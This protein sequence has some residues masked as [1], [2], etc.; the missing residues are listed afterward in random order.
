MA[1]TPTVWQDRISVNPGQFSATGSIPGN[2]TLTL[3]DNPTQAGTPVTAIRMNNIESGIYKNT[4]L[5][6]DLIQGTSQVPTLTGT[7]ITQITHKD[8]NNNVLRTDVFRYLTLT[9]SITNGNFAN[10]PTGWSVNNATGFSVSNSLASFTA[11]A[12]EGSL[13]QGLSILAGHQ[14]YACASVSSTGVGN[15]SMVLSDSVATFASNLI[16]I[17]GGFVVASAYGTSKTTSS[18]G[19]FKINDERTSGWTPIQVDNV[20]VLDLTAI[21]GAGNE[22]SQDAMDAMMSLYGYFDNASRIEE[23]RTLSTGE[24]VS[25]SYHF[26]SI[27]NF[28]GEVIV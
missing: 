9:N 14:Y 7:T 17:T 20:V 5:Y 19:Q 8:T 16:G 2:V 10:G 24:T 11:T 23:T 25:L 12:L 21:W 18:S 4:Q 6:N 27:G 28:V 15:V 22:P 13:I 26:D 1:Y 3:N